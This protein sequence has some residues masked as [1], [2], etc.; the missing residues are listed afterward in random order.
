MGKVGT[1]MVV[2]TT[3]SGL[4]WGGWLVGSQTPEGQEALAKA[5]KDFRENKA[6]QYDT[7]FFAENAMRVF[8][9]GD[10]GLLDSTP[11]KPCLA[12]AAGG[13]LFI[14]D[15]GSGASAA[16]ERVGMP[17]NRLHAVLLTGAD[18]VRAGDLD[19]LWAL[20]SAQRQNRPLPV[21]GPVDAHRL[22]FGLNDAM[23]AQTG[24]SGLEAW[25][26]APA[27]GQPVV[28]YKDDQLEVL[29]YTTDQDAFSN[30]VGYVFNYRGRILTIAPNGSAAWAAAA[31]GQ[32]DVMLQTNFAEAFAQLH[33]PDTGNMMAGLQQFAQAAND[34]DA[35]TLVLA[36]AGDNP[37][38]NEMSKRVARD[39]GMANVVTSGNGMV[40][41]LPLENRDVNVRRL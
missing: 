1:S 10:G 24:V 36:N 35:N 21:Y 7:D 25:A 32:T 23:G 31:P 22:V 34:A 39:A 41:E 37:I 29:A 20:A 14:I 13:K 3:L 6:Q 9:C 26:P 40:L 8:V 38:V 4:I 17:L 16:L 15:A 19:E 18:Q 12:V 5:Y 11:S 2:F 33:N 30:K 28:V 27:P